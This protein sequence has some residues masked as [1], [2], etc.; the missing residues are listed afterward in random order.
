M[1]G[2]RLEPAG[3]RFRV[4]APNADAAFV[5]YDGHWTRETAFRLTRDG[6]YFEGVAPGIG[7]GTRY[8][9][10]LVE[11]ARE[12][13]R[14]DPAARDTTH[15][16]LSDPNNG[17]FV[18]APRAA[19]PDFRTPAFENLII[20]QLHPGSFAGRNDEFAGT[21]IGRA[22]GFPMLQQKLEYVRSMGFNAVQLL[23]IQEYHEDRSWGYNPSFF[24]SVE[25]AYGTPDQ[26]RD[27]VARAH[28]LGLA[29]I[30][31]VV[32]NHVSDT[33]NPLWNW[34][35]YQGD[36]EH[37][38]Y[39]YPPH[40]TDW[41]PGPAFEKQAVRDFFVENALMLF[42]EYRI[43]GLRFDATRT[44]EWNRGGANH[45]WDFLGELTWRI[46]ELYPEKY[47]IAEHLPDDRGI[48]V[49]AGMSATWCAASHHE[50]QRAAQGD[51]PVNRV[52]SFL[53]RDLGPERSYPA[54]WNLVKYC[55]GSHDD[56]GDDDQ[57]E[58]IRRTD[59]EQHRYFV[60]FF[61]GRDN[62]HA[63]AKARLGWAVN[64]AAIGTPMLFAGLECHHWGYWHDREDRNGDRRFDWGIAGDPTGVEMRR[65]VAAA[66]EAR[67]ANPCLRGDTLD[68]VHQDFDN[69]VLAWKRYLLGGSNC[70]L[71]VANLGD[72]NFTDRS[73]GVSTGGQRGQWTQILCTQDA[74]YGG[75]DG[76]GNAF[77]DPWTEND[78]MIYINVPQWSVIL[79]RLL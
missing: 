54:G 55:L 66:N 39:L 9:Y 33:D 11:G 53:G 34:D 18:V 72:R 75:W 69:Q 79:L 56:C 6:A 40:S 68:V 63:R 67:W 49:D 8:K 61:G 2:A 78:G 16:G 7:A 26:L 43:D 14:M 48:I 65:L 73:Y 76:A 45:G 21:A 50:F 62:W 58:S 28:E 31:D 57:G 64:V 15:S 51:D 42:D 24:F 37:G 27:F 71:A 30:F 13:W 19:W 44:I 35:V 23:P 10:I 25:S 59:W 17:A 74:A 22:A 1:I 47:L 52:R 29:V 32:Y 46:K 12:I 3:T 5:A 60:E 38:E 77:H 4:W 20:Y 36:G 70:V 41:G